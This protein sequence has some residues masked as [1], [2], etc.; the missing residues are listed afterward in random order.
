[1][2]NSGVLVVVGVCPL[3]LLDAAMNVAPSVEEMKCRLC[4]TLPILQA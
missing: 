3:A 2:Y 4:I 1:M